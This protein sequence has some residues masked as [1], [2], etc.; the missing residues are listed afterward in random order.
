[1]AESL[2][3][4]MVGHPT[5]G[6]SGVVAAELALY[7]ATQG[8]E[9][10]F[11]SHDYPVRLLQNGADVFFHE[12]RPLDYP[13]FK[14]P[15]FELAF[16]SRLLE[17]VRHHHLDLL[18]VHYAI[19]HA[20]IA[21]SVK[22]ILHEEGIHLPFI[23]TL[24]GTDSTLLGKDP[25]YHPVITHTLRHADAITVVSKFLW[26]DCQRTFCLERS[27]HVIPNFVNLNIFRP[28]YSKE[29]RRRYAPDDVMLLIHVSNFRPVKRIDWVLDTFGEIR[30]HI[31]C[32][33]L[34]IGDG[35]EQGWA[36]NYVR[37]MGWEQ[38][39]F[40]LGKMLDLAPYYSIA[41]AFLLTSET[42]SFGLAALEAMAC[43]TPV[44][45]FS[46]GGLPEVVRHG[47]TG[48]LAPLGDRHALAHHAVELWHDAA[49]RQSMKSNARQWA[50]QFDVEQIAPQYTQL[51][52]NVTTSSASPTP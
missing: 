47:Q 23:V 13:L 22:N 18:H 50:E 45:A 37:S 35:P 31:A 11:F 6:G 24:H 28:R 3:I 4:G 44:L 19:P 15:P 7:L 43:S 5:Y 33:L 41:D 39:V 30:Q 51:Y 1:M 14:H 32:R 20:F 8:C 46:V 52:Q 9:V 42:E 40:F 10:H 25:S 36:E 49:R 16:I 48:M 26:E 34:M 12:V 17:V 29:L 38:E 21:L 2:R 27:P